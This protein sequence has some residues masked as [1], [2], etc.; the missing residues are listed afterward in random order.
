MKYEDVHGTVY[1]NFSDFSI[2]AC[3][4]SQNIGILAICSNLDNFSIAGVIYT[5]F[6]GVVIAGVV[7]SIFNLMSLILM[8]PNILAR[9][10][11]QHYFN[12][13]IYC[14]GCILYLFIS[15]VDEIEPIPNE[16]IDVKS[17]IGI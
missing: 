12:G 15:N 8:R 2:F 14:I 11:I 6:T 13:P 4:V 1:A 5:T 17:D 3:N 7:I 9:L 16:I 10:Y